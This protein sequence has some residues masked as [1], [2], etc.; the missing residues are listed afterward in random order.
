N[1]TITARLNGSK[2][3]YRIIH[4]KRIKKRIANSK[5]SL[6]NLMARKQGYSAL[7]FEK[8]GERAF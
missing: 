5:Y 4:P 2:V 8:A 3:G 6:I 1:R 7:A